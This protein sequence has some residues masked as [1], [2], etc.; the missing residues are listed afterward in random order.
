MA[1]R[2]TVRLSEN[3]RRALD[4]YARRSGRRPSE[5]VR[6]ALAAHLRVGSEPRR[7]ADRVSDL[8]GSLESGV[9]DLASRHRHYVLESLRN[10]R[11]PRTSEGAR[12]SQDM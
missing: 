1:T 9:A 5:I 2:I 11:F 10:R 12:R 8:F 3:L 7:P 6:T 4:A